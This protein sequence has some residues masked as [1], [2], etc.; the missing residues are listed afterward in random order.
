MNVARSMIVDRRFDACGFDFGVQGADNIAVEVKGL[1][2]KRGEIL[3]T[4]RE[5]NEARVRRDN[6]LLVVVGNLDDVPIVRTIGNPAAT[7]DPSCSYYTSIAV[8][9]RASVGV[10]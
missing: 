1:K 10:V 5:W 6:Y 3:F 8:T 9:W 7:L 2:R 4:D